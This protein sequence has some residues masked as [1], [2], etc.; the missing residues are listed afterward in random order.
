MSFGQAYVALRPGV[1]KGI[2]GVGMIRLEFEQVCQVGFKNLGL[3]DPFGRERA[4][5]VVY[6]PDVE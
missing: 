3:A 6:V 5:I 2:E 4:G 1:A